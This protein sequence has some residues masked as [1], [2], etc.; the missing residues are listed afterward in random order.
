MFQKEQS[1]RNFIPDQP[2]QE[3]PFPFP[4]PFQLFYPHLAQLEMKSQIP[5]TRQIIFPGF[6]EK[7]EEVLDNLCVHCVYYSELS[8]PEGRRQFYAMESRGVFRGSIHVDLSFDTSNKIMSIYLKVIVP[9]LSTPLIHRINVK[10]KRGSNFPDIFRKAVE[11]A[12][13]DKEFFDHCGIFALS[14]LMNPAYKKPL[15]AVFQRIIINLANDLWEE[16]N[17]LARCK[18]SK[19]SKGE[20]VNAAELM[21]IFQKNPLCAITMLDDRA[22]QGILG[23]GIAEMLAAAILERNVTQINKQI[24]TNSVPRFLYIEFERI[25][26]EMMRSQ[27]NLRKIFQQAPQLSNQDLQRQSSFIGTGNLMY[28][29]IFLRLREIG[30]NNQAATA[31]TK[32]TITAI[33]TMYA[34]LFQN[35]SGSPPIEIPRF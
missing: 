17:D 13:N 3:F 27:F 18:A 4:F 11:L 22:L 20:K 15:V 30:Y 19:I 29:G 24:L 35:E 31:L 6:H 26:Q 33:A 25:V 9:S 12:A 23:S 10:S 34:T 7:Y 32:A 2:N 8:T 1:I 28:F 14:T 21:N 16:L 5:G